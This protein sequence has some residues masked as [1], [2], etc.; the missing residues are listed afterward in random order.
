MFYAFLLPLTVTALFAATWV[1]D[2]RLYRGN[3]R[4]AARASAVAA[5][6]A[7]TRAFILGAVVMAVL[8]ILIAP[9]LRAVLSISE[10]A[11]F[12]CSI[13]SISFSPVTWALHPPA[14]LI[15]GS[16]HATDPRLL[17]RRLRPAVRGNGV[18]YF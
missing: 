14:V 11:F 9:F 17:A 2:W 16:L 12:L 5:W 4:A 10:L 15:L 18:I 3:F 8:T 7:G 13:G 1:R 6:K